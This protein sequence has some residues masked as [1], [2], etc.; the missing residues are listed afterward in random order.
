MILKI[1]SDNFLAAVTSNMIE[2]TKIG[3]IFE[4]R[5]YLILGRMK[6]TKGKIIKENCV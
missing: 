2:A 3:Y 1:I 4:G 5:I 6:R